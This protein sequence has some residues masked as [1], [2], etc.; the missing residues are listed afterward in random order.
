M[1]KKFI[2]TNAIDFYRLMERV[3]ILEKKTPGLRI[4][5]KKLSNF[6]M[7]VSDFSTST[8]SISA[9]TKVAILV[10]DGEKNPDP[11]TLSDEK[12]MA[13]FSF[14]DILNIRL[15][16]KLNKIAKSHNA[17]AKLISVKAVEDAEKVKDCIALVADAAS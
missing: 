15:T 12:D 6:L 10:T 4:G 3:K 9:Q 17:A 1:S 13:D 14:S 16:G 8:S 5:N 2:K 7:E 11:T